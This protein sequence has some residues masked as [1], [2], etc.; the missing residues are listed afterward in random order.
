MVFPRRLFHANALL[1]LGPAI[2]TLYRL[3]PLSSGVGDEHASCCNQQLLMVCAAAS[4]NLRGGESVKRATGG[5][6]QSDADRQTVTISAVKPLPSW[7]KITN[8]C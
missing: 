6:P 2:L 5:S 4:A 3:K 7:P 1:V 8:L